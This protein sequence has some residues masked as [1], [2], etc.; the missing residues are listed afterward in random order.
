VSKVNQNPQHPA[1]FWVV[2]NAISI[3]TIQCQWQEKDYECGAL[4]Q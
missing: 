2:T 1:H 4:F 3:Y